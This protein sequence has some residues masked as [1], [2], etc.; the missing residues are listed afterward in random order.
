M[1]FFH[2][3]L[4]ILSVKRRSPLSSAVQFFCTIKAYLCCFTQFTGDQTK[5]TVNGSA[6]SD[7]P[8]V[9]YL[10]ALYIQLNTRAKENQHLGFSIHMELPHRFV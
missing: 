10:V 4:G 9:F 6:L 8:K 1:H 7:T 2:L 5:L 3:A